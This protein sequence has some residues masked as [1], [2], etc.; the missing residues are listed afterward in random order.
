MFQGEVF[1]HW[2]VSIT[3][4]YIL[5]L[6]HDFVLR[7]SSIHHWGS[8]MTQYPDHLHC[9][10]HLISTSPCLTAYSIVSIIMLCSETPDNSAVFLMNYLAHSHQLQ[11][12]H[13]R[14]DCVLLWFSLSLSIFSI[15]TEITYICE[16]K[17]VLKKKEWHSLFRCRL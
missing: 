12:I 1:W 11:T 9:M 14:V 13:K 10:Y 16:A 2:K 17:K 15:F 5:T 8:Y 4:K 3:Q 6:R 7:V